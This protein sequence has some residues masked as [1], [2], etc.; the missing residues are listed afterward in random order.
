[1]AE[2]AWAWRV[3]TDADN[4]SQWLRSYQSGSIHVCTIFLNFWNI[5]WLKIL[6][7]FFPNF[8][9]KVFLKIILF[10]CHN[11]SML[12]HI[13]FWWKPSYWTF[14]KSYFTTYLSNVLMQLFLREMRK[15]RSILWLWIEWL[16]HVLCWSTVSYGHD[17]K[18]IYLKMKS[19][20]EINTS[21]F[22][23]VNFSFLS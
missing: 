16:C 8:W 15:S 2:A 18:S 14:Y 3:M 6:F 9:N 11:C 23:I 17:Q 19:L 10:S 21:S 22:I 13:F 7:Y 1:M 4:C 5:V 20:F 12:K